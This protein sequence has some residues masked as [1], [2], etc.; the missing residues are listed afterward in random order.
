MNQTS[1]QIL[2]M[3]AA[4]LL[5]LLAVTDRGWAQSVVTAVV[6]DPLTGVALGGTD[7]VSYFTEGSPLPGSPQFEF[8]W[9]GAPW[10]FANQA[11][12]DV[13]KR[14]PEI[15]APQFGGHDG[16]A[17]SRGYVSDGD[18][19][20]YA[21]FKSRV[22]LFYSPANREAFLIAPDAAAARAEANWTQL[23]KTLATQ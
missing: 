9:M 18:P 22:Y 10:H 21:V 6:T 11:N 8:G 13:F 20:Y 7:P 16:M 15:Y 23:A 3:L 5:A 12:L 1:K 4:L 14:A 19:R 17:A 2:T